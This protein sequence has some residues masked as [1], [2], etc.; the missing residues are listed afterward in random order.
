MAG[1]VTGS[2]GV[3]KNRAQGGRCWSLTSLRRIQDGRRAEVTS[4]R[5]WESSKGAVT[6]FKAT[7]LFFRPL[8]EPA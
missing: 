4:R 1:A 5:C 8:V 6:H 2:R 3:G 7:S